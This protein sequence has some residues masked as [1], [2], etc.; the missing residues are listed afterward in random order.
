MKFAVGC[1]TLREMSVQE[2]L[3]E[4]TKLEP[5]ELETVSRRATELQQVM[6][7]EVSE[8]QR[9]SAETDAP[10]H[11]RSSL[12]VRWAGKLEMPPADPSDPR[13]TY[14]LERYERDRS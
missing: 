5:A 7:R 2:I 11:K 12:A 8:L 9:V 1:S 13:L 6:T 3:E 14:L 4:L 10:G